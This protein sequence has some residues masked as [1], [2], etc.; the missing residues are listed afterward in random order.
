MLRNIIFGVLVIA[1][2]FAAA[3]WVMD[4][5]WPDPGP[6]QR[7]ALTAV[8]PL[9]SVTRTSVIV[10]PAA[11]AHSAIRDAMEAAAPRNFAGKRESP[12]KDLGLNA[13]IGWTIDRGPLAVAGRPEGLAV[14]TPLT[15]TLRATG[16]IAEQITGQIGNLSGALGGLAGSLGRDVQKFAGKP[17]DQRGDIR[18]NVLVTSRPSIAP[19]WRVAPNLTARVNIADVAMSIAG[20]RLS[21][22]KEV[23]PFVDR[24]VGEQVAALEAKV[25]NDPFL[26]QTARRE[27]AK[28][29]R[30]I[31][32]GAVGSGVPDLWL[33]LRP[34][35]A[36]AAQ[37]RVDAN[38]VTLV[39][40][41]Q[42]E[43]RVVPAETK[44][45]CPFP[46]KI[47]IVPQTEQGRIA[48]GVPIDVPFTE[49]NKL[50]EA[51][52]KGR[53]FPEDGSAPVEVTVRRA[54]VAASGDRL[55]I[56][57]LVKANEKKSWFGFGAEATIHVWG[58]PVLDKD[59]QILRLTD[60][61]LDVQSEAAFGLLGA[62]AQAA[63]PQLRAA[64]AERTTVDLKPFAA[65]AR[66]RIAAAI[67]DFREQTAGVRVD[68]DITDLRLVGIEFDATTLR[69]IAEADGNV[70]V[71]VTALPA[72]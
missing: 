6:G 19:N 57:L 40:G 62:A 43:T 56:S 42:A 72:P 52:L 50:L 70:K 44:P 71:A 64:L 29:C 67:A 63:R 9:E 38:A 12:A 60:V 10:T 15:G 66:K 65:D 53:S 46:E 35:K 18:G 32:L 30:S 54:T 61:E 28:M 59:K 14:T 39:L 4:W 2:S 55:L 27:W 41:V 69:V 20:I 45:T 24:S 22:A 37:P 25:R 58:R 11:I 26:E 3:T 7:P 34:T 8:A 36:F 49:V 47:E 16:Q 31:S 5:M 48:I 51:Q 33:E 1:V 68:T 21:V 13:D 17:F 23:R